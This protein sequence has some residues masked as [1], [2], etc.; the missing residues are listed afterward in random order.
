MSAFSGASG[1]PFGRRQPR[2]DGFED[3]ADADAFL[4]A[5]EN[6]ARRVEADDLFDLPPAL[7]DLR[8]GQ[9]DLVDD[10]DDLEVAV[11]GEVGV[12]QRLRLDAL[13]GVDEQQRALAGAPASG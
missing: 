4:G 10:R 1:S 3:V 8:A 2:D 11:D 7:L 13:R 9:I 6:R 12:G 5:G